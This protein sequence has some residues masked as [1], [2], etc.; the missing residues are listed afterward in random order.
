M[1]LVACTTAI[2]PPSFVRRPL[3]LSFGRVV[4]MCPSRH[5]DASGAEEFFSLI[6]VYFQ[7]RTIPPGRC[8]RWRGARQSYTQKYTHRKVQILTTG[9]CGQNAEGLLAISKTPLSTIQNPR[10]DASA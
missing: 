3:P 1:N 4:T 6:L 7:V 9:C 10:I 8:M 5:G 2:L